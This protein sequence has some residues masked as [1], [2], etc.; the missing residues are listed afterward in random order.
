MQRMTVLVTGGTGAIGSNVARLLITKGKKVVLYDRV[1]LSPANRVLAGFDGELKVEIGNITDMASLFDVIKRHDVRGVI[2][3][4]GMLPPHMNNLHPIE[5]LTV[6]IIGT[7]NVLEAARILGL[8][9]VIVASAAGVMG[10]PKDVLTPRKEEDVVLPLAGIYPLSKLACEQLVYTYRQLHKVDTTAVRPRNAY[11]PGFN[12]RMQPLFEVIYAALDGKDFV[13]PSG[14]DSIFDYTYVK[15]TAAGFVQ[16]Y[17]TKAPANYVYNLSY[18]KGVN[19][20]QVI[21]VVKPVFP[22]LKIEVGPGPWEGVVE[23]GKE[24][25]LT[26]HPAVMPVQDISRA[27]KDFGYS[28]EWDIERGIPDWVRWLKTGTYD[29]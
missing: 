19:M 20:T 11:G 9:P 16:L 27:R 24:S 13:R 28:P 14:G 8:G 23:G 22:K 3:C 1:P 25:E 5:A 18:G 4:A 29:G 2:H 10:R 7:A 12:F 21:D 17:E 15:D 26:V 6:N